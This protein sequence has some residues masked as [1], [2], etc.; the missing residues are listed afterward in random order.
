MKNS[1]STKNGTYFLLLPALFSKLFIICCLILFSCFLS[2]QTDSL[3]LSATE[4]NTPLTSVIKVSNESG[5][6]MNLYCYELDGDIVLLNMGLLASGRSATIRP[7]SELG[8]L[9]TKNLLTDDETA[10][11]Y[12][13]GGDY[14]LKI[15][16][17]CG[18]KLS[19][20]V[21]STDSYNC[22]DLIA[23]IGDSCNDGIKST[24]DDRITA[25][26]TC[27][28]TRTTPITNDC[29]SVSI[30]T[31]G[32]SILVS[33]L[34][35]SQI[36][37]VQVLTIDWKTIYTCAGNCQESELIYAPDDS[38]RVKVS[39]YTKAW[40]HVCSV[41][42]A[43]PNRNNFTTDNPAFSRTAI[44]NAS[45]LSS[46]QHAMWEVYPNPVRTALTVN[47]ANNLS[48]SIRLSTLSGQLIQEVTVSSLVKSTWQLDMGPLENGMYLL[49]LQTV[50]GELET[51]KIIVSK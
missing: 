38:L 45:S 35:D 6:D 12:F 42:G 30:L 25:N 16:T 37:S 32:D 46:N 33:N 41:W 4:T 44:N 3:I 28:G 47:V 21:L 5:C 27:E 11:V 14:E 13:F 17:G 9:Y 10:S 1:L 49:Q 40:A 34:N 39:Y 26:C 8:R 18:P 36:N 48:G 51:R 29:D 15:L 23:N 24:M 19:D 22:I 20:D 43:V 2:A 50:D 7:K 31:I